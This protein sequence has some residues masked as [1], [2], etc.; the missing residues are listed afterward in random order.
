MWGGHGIAAHSPSPAPPSHTPDFTTEFQKSESSEVFGTDQRCLCTSEDAT[1]QRE[2]ATC[3][4]HAEGLLLGLEGGDFPRQRINMTFRDMWAYYW[5][6]VF[7]AQCEA[8][9]FKS[10]AK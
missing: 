5:L 1:P 10:P 4:S 6:R 2:E 3:P 8:H 7:L 9:F